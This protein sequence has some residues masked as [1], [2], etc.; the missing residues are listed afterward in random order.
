MFEGFSVA[1]V[2]PFQGGAVD[3]DATAR[4]VEHMIEGGVEGLVVSGSTGEA[5][6]C[7]V[8]E[9][10]DL[11]KFV[12]E[13]AKG[14]I[15]V[16]AGTGTNDTAQSIVLTK[17]AEDLGMDG[18]MVVT[19]FYNKPT[20]KG[21][22][23]HFRA[24]ATSTKLPV[25]LY[26]VPG[27]TGTNTKPETL[28]MVQD[29][30]N[31]VA[32]KEASGDLDQMTQVRQKTRF[33]LLSGDDALTLPCVAAGGSGI[34]SVVGQLVPRAMRTLSDAARAGRLEE[35]RQVNDRLAGIFKAA[36]IE[37][38][39]APAKF[40]L[41]EMGLVRNELRLPLLPVEPASEKVILEA[42]RAAG[43]ALP[44]GARA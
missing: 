40:L 39:P 31:I 11:W 27:R 33:T 34:I 9:R 42:A 44:A 3:H 37:S 24:V 26:N 14:R 22:A 41:S 28:A 25:I 7:T 17:M 30:P 18:A 6:T 4:L 15:W 29:V 10:R 43:V 19:P 1:M 21:Q 2:T 20:P 12:K 13:R 32:V 16:V 8:E 36:F 35:A 5:A 38:N 23:A